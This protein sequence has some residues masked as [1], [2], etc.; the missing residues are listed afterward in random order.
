MADAKQHSR[1]SNAKLAGLKYDPKRGIDWRMG[2]LE[3]KPELNSE[4]ESAPSDWLRQTQAYR[5]AIMHPDISKVSVT[6][7]L[8]NKQAQALTQLCNH[9]TLTDRRKFTSNDDEALQL[10]AG[11]L[12]LQKAL[13]GTGY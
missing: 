6:L 5:N 10:H 3:T 7:E 11:L 4:C 9:I 1:G 13:T 12:E 8:S 2:W